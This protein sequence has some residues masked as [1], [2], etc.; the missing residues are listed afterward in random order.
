[1]KKGSSREKRHREQTAQ[2]ETVCGRHS[3]VKNAFEPVT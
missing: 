3:P 1:M 2:T